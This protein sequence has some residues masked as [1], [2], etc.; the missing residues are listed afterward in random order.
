MLEPG[1]LGAVPRGLTAG[2]M[3]VVQRRMSRERKNNRR[4]Q[5][6]DMAPLSVE[7]LAR[8]RQDR[9]K[10]AGGC[11]HGACNL[12]PPVTTLPHRPPPS[13]DSDLLI[14]RR[15]SFRDRQRT[16]GCHAGILEKRFVGTQAAIWIV[17][18]VELPI[19]LRNVN[20]TPEA[21]PS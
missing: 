18:S 1:P 10:V 21:D 5:Q 13:A 6:R 16:P 12:P 4:D 9:M 3:D 2:L 7:R 15:C 20:L 19:W 11:V 14:Y 17:P 8:E